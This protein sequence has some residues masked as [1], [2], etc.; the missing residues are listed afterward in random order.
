MISRPTLR[1][2]Y[3]ALIAALL[4][5][6]EESRAPG[7]TVA[8]PERTPVEVDGPRLPTSVPRVPEATVP[9][10]PSLV[11]RAPEATVP[12]SPSPVPRVPDR[13]APP[14]VEPIQLPTATGITREQADVYYPPAPRDLAATVAGKG[15]LLTWEPGPVPQDA[16]YDPE[17]SYYRVYRAETPDRYAIV[18]EPTA[19]RWLDE[20]VEPGMSYWYTV[21]AVYGKGHEGRRPDPVQVDVP[22]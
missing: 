2:L 3:L 5:A 4:T 16:K 6:C 20:D 21:T 18:A 14:P 1:L 11:P 8:E 15:V 13:L 12:P 10:R 17:L 19:A 22:R 9:L 7:G